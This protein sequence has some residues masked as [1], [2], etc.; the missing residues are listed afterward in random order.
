MTKLRQACDSLKIYDLFSANGNE[1][2]RLW[3]RSQSSGRESIC[4]PGLCLLSAKL[5]QRVLQRTQDNNG[6]GILTE[7]INRN[8]LTAFTTMTNPNFTRNIPKTHIRIGSVFYY[9]PQ[10]IYDILVQLYNP[11]PTFTLYQLQQEITRIRAVYN[12]PNPNVLQDVPLSQY[13]KR[14]VYNG[15][16]KNWQYEQ[17]KNMTVTQLHPINYKVLN[18]VEVFDLN[19][20]NQMPFLG[21]FGLR[22]LQPQN[23]QFIT[24]VQNTSCSYSNKISD[25]FPNGNASYWGSGILPIISK[26]QYYINGSM[27]FYPQFAIVQPEDWG[28]YIGTPS[29]K[30]GLLIGMNDQS[31]LYFKS[32]LTPALL[33]LF[34]QMLIQLLPKL[35]TNSELIFIPIQN[36]VELIQNED[37]KSNTGITFPL[38]SGGIQSK[39]G[40]EISLIEFNKN[41]KKYFQIKNP[42]Y[43]LLQNNEF[44]TDFVSP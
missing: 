1:P 18:L 22:K 4:G 25:L 36:E 34:E 42:N 21:N 24:V 23:A 14:Y 5:K 29:L 15:N 12:L 32:F 9:I 28:I 37:Y 13:K 40:I 16:N 43:K 26:Q 35:P 44:I 17:D 3:S 2:P 27:L 11:L 30:F 19:I 10:N 38:L 20:F 39:E 8:Q 7:R 31:I 33:V 6:P 41:A